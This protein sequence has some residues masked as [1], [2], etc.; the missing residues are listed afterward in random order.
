[1]N[2]YNYLKAFLTSGWRDSSDR[3]RNAGQSAADAT[4]GAVAAQIRNASPACVRHRYHP[5]S[6]KFMNLTEQIMLCGLQL[7]PR[8]GKEHRTT[9]HAVRLRQSG[10]GWPAIQSD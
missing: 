10:A 1:M 4:R 8:P 9:V 5:D 6:T 7:L 2:F 3:L